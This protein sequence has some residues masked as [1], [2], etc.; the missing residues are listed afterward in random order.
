MVDSAAAKSKPSLNGMVF[1][2]NCGSEMANTGQRYCCPKAALASGDN[3]PT[4][5][6]DAEHLVRSVVTAIVRRLATEDNVRRIT[7][8]IKDTTDANARAQRSRMEH[9]EAAIS[10]ADSRRPAVLQ[11]VEYGAKKYDDVV[12]EISKLDQITAGLA[13]ESMVA[14]DELDKIDFISDEDGIRDAAS[15]PE[16]YLGGNSPDEVQELLDLL[17]QKVMADAKSATILYEVAMPSAGQPEGISEDPILL[18]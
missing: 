9:A 4:M 2:A 7:E 17:V 13:F 15:N 3:C 12:D 14:R 8:T 11:P 10:E 18:D 6:V 5:P 16:T 1:C